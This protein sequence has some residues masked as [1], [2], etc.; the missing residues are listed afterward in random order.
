MRTSVG[1]SHTY[2]V[3]HVSLDEIAS[4][5]ESEGIYVHV[6]VCVCVGVHM[7]M[8]KWGLFPIDNGCLVKHQWTILWMLCS[9]HLDLRMLSSVMMKNQIVRGPSYPHHVH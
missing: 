3:P 7:Y 8:G 6:C 1:V 4:Y 9:I 5:L 2:E